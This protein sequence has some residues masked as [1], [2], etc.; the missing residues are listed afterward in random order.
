MA[1][2]HVVSSQQSAVSSL[3]VILGSC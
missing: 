3:T 2:M 1:K